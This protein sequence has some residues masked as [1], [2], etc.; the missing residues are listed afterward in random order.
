MW[1]NNGGDFLERENRSQEHISAS[2][3]QS[4][5]KYLLA[6]LFVHGTTISQQW[7]WKRLYNLRTLLKKK[8]NERSKIYVNRLNESEHEIYITLT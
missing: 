7:N 3:W 8:N 6:Y 2:T 1:D 5:R 4:P